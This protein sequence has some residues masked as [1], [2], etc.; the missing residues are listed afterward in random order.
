MRRTVSI[1]NSPTFS[2]GFT[3]IEVALSLL[4]SGAIITGLFIGMKSLV[5][6]YQQDWVLL[7]V[8]RYGNLSLDR[9]CQLLEKARDVKQDNWMGYDRLDIQNQREYLTL[10]ANPQEGFLLDNRPL[11]AGMPFPN[12][13][14]YRNNNQRIITLEKFL[15][16]PIRNVP[17]FNLQGRHLA[18]FARSLWDIQLVMS[19]AQNYPGEPE[20]KQYVNFHRRV[21]IPRIYLR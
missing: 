9:I 6:Y 2:S 20:S 14:Q 13:G 16:R 18:R 3:L 7:D 11:L 19:I 4:V 5:G 8:R 1:A 12:I 15:C 21:F 10:L 17:G